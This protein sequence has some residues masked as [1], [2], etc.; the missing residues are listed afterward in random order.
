MKDEP[1]ADPVSQLEFY[2]MIRLRLEHEDGLIVQRL[3][4]LVASQS[5]LFTAYAITLNGLVTNI[6]TV[7]TRQSHL[8]NVVATVGVLTCGL[9]YASIL[10]AI[11]AINVLR[12]E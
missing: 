8:M 10:A 4:W 11:A 9:L 12:R 2:R 3:S 6:A 7:T 5:F 1:L